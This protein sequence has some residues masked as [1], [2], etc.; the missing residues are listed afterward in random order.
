MIQSPRKKKKL[1]ENYI[2]F[3]NSILNN[4][5]TTI[6]EVKMK[7]IFFVNIYMY[8]IKK[9]ITRNYILVM[10]HLKNSYVEKEKYLSI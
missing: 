9:E 2:I 4:Y 6:M 1:N 3:F 7:I 8:I 10:R 5:I